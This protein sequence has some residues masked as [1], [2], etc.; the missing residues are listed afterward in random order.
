LTEDKNS[1]NILDIC[2]GLGFNTLT[3]ILYYKKYAP[4][5]RVHIVSPELDEKLVKTLKDFDYPDEFKELKEIIDSISK[6]F[7]YEDEQ[8]KVEVIIGDA[9]EL[10][11]DL[12]IK[13]DIIYQD[14]F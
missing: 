6:N 4:D 5:K 14:A 3:T 11:K 8:F 7:F 12:D 9:R 1:L 2:F 13:F 10:I